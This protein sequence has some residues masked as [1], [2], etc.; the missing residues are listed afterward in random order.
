LA[1]G[2]VTACVPAWNAAEFIEATLD[3]LVAQ[4][5]ADLRILISVD[6][7]TDDTS[8][9]CDAYAST[10]S[11]VS[12]V[13]QPT[14]LG[15]VGNVNDLLRRVDSEY[16]MFAFHDDLLAPQYV[17]QLVE[18]LEEHPRAVLAF[19]DLV[20]TYPD[21][22][23]EVSRYSAL[24]GV[25]DPA[26]RAGSIIR[27]RGDWW[28][29]HRGVFRTA[30]G[31][32]IGG[33]QRNHAGEFSADWPWLLHLSL[34]GEFVRHPEVL[35]FKYYKSSSLS[36]GWDRTAAEQG[37]VALSCLREVARARIPFGVK[38]AA[39]RAVAIPCFVLI[40]PWLV[41]A[42]SWLRTLRRR[43]RSGTKL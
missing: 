29:P 21:G 32:S 23:E 11:N 6:L 15:W 37:A 10:R 42:P 33:L 16:T 7:S 34:R 13:H 3:S 26:E 17:A 8:A 5:Y 40:R 25:T 22:R 4:T 14:R 12:V 19:S 24:D 38:L 43:L 36:R 2:V 20:T 9:V 1:D 31:R 30:V 18:L 41:P 35:C 27:K 28:A 39:L